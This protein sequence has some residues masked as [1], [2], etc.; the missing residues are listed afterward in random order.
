[1]FPKQWSPCTTLLTSGNEKFD[2]VVSRPSS[3]SWRMLS[4][5]GYIITSRIRNGITCTW[6]I[7]RRLQ[8]RQHVSGEKRIQLR[9]NG[10]SKRERRTTTHVKLL[11]YEL[12]ESKDITNN[13]LSP[14]ESHTVMEKWCQH[15]K[16][17]PKDF[18]SNIVKCL[19]RQIKKRM[20]FT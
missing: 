1:M 20:H 13:C 19:D 17:D 9:K 2:T 14:K 16:I 3:A 12:P 10:S 5:K 8:A 11:C 4:T 6:I 15:K 18:V 7:S